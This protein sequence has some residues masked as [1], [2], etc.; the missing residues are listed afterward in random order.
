MHR[1]VVF[2]DKSNM[3]LRKRKVG[4]TKQF[5]I[6]IIKQPG[7]NNNN[8]YRYYIKNRRYGQE[9]DQFEFS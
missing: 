4:P 9:S 3:L 2:K 1:S 5:G 8:E 6:G 7:E